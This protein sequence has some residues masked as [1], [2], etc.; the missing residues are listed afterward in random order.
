[1]GDARRSGNG[2]HG[3]GHE[4][5][6]QRMTQDAAAHHAPVALTIAGSDSSGGA[7][8]QADLKT[9]TVL[10]VY[11]ASVLTALTA[12]S[13]EGVSSILA[14]PPEF[15]RLQIDAVV[16]DF[17]ISAVKTGMLN[18]RETVVAV[19]KACRHYK[20][21]P[22]VVDPV[23][24]ATSGDRLLESD[25]IQAMRDELFPSSD[26]LTPNLHEAAWLLDQPVA[27][28]E[29]GM[30]AQARSLLGLGCKAV[31][32][33]GGHGESAEAIDLLVEGEAVTRLALPRI[34]TRNTHGTG[35]TFSAAIAANLA[36]GMALKS[37]VLDAK[38]FVHEALQ[39]AAGLSL[40][41]G[42][43]PI[44][45]LQHERKRAPRR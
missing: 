31:V 29:A 3:T 11:G 9:F 42:C 5:V 16:G 7:G 13:S 30:I 39:A 23:I 24:V 18:N 33:K 8:I 43:G 4:P 36:Q 19:A 40:G 44:D 6:D 45:F 37:A 17:A 25:A 26:I 21:H 41:K 10:R 14:V 22:L 2:N 27:K 12:Q 28:D 15:I 34:N 1:M 35:C 38:R 20:L 32:I